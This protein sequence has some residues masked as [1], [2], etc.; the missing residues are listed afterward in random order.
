MSASAEIA[1]FFT[2]RSCSRPSIARSGATALRSRAFCRAWVAVSRSKG[3]GEP[4]FASGSSIEGRSVCGFAS[5]SSAADA[6]SRFAGSGSWTTTRISGSFA[7]ASP[8]IASAATARPRTVGS[9]SLSAASSASSAPVIRCSPARYAAH[10]RCPASGSDERIGRRSA[11]AIGRRLSA[12]V[13]CPCISTSPVQRARKSATPVSACAP[14]ASE[15]VSTAP[16]AAVLSSDAAAAA[17][18]E[19]P[20]TS[21]AGAVASR[22]AKRNGVTGGT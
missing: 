9:A 7:R 10:A 15:S 12:L 5:C 20:V 2:E 18:P 13:P 4:S 22:I 14:P 3:S 1:P 17:A 19:L 11:G 8:I 21:G 16:I 6:R